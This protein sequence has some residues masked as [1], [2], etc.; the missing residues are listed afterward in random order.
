MSCLTSI[1]GDMPAIRKAPQ[2]QTQKAVSYQASKFSQ[3]LEIHV[4]CSESEGKQ[5]LKVYTGSIIE[6]PSRPSPHRRT[7]QS[8]YV[9]VTDGVDL[10][11]LSG[12]LCLLRGPSEPRQ[13]Q[14]SHSTATHSHLL[15]EP[16][17]TVTAAVRANRPNA[18]KSRDQSPI[19]M[20]SALASADPNAMPR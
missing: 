15:T 13:D 2:K 8:P 19:L 5:P 7:C 18:P 12:G 14:L 20:P 1:I 16:N 11:V 6:A 9:S 10:Q 17:A 4:V 3:R